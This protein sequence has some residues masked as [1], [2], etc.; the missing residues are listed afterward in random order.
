VGK[1]QEANR[2]KGH[3]TARPKGKRICKTQ[4]DRQKNWPLKG[5]KGVWY[6]HHQTYGT[7]SG[8]EEE[9]TK[10]NIWEEN[11]RNNMRSE[12][13]NKELSENG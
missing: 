4:T 7:V 12:R 1:G 11:G 2:R 5:T 6:V 8:C 9:D 3:T 13:G 10:E